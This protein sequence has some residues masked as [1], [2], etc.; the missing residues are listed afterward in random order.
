MRLRPGRQRFLLRTGTRFGAAVALIGV[1]VLTW[2]L[3]GDALLTRPV[4]PPAGDPGRFVSIDG[5]R[6]YYRVTGVGPAV[7]LLHGLGSS[8]L[9]WDAT[10]DAL[11]ESFTV[12]SLDLPGFGYS[13]KPAG[14][15]TARQE[16][17]FVDRFL[18]ALGIERA[19]VVG[20]SMGGAVARAAVRIVARKKWAITTAATISV[21]WKA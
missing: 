7:V 13:D 1:L 12:Y 9:T 3:T 10:T 5:L 6:T 11:A 16:A 15:A 17:A 20:H 19:T 2:Y 4:D 14:Y 8:H 21:R 18:S